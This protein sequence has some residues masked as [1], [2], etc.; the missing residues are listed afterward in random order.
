MNEKLK[1]LFVLTIVLL[2]SGCFQVTEMLLGCDDPPTIT[3][4]V[5]ETLVQTVTV[6]PP[7]ITSWQYYWWHAGYNNLR[8]YPYQRR[9]QLWYNE[10]R[11]CWWKDNVDP[12]FRSM[13]LQRYGIGGPS[14]WAL[15]QYNVTLKSKRRTMI[16]RDTK[17]GVDRYVDHGVPT[18]SFLRAVLSN[19]LFEAVIKADSDNQLALTDICR[20]IHDY[21]PNT[22][23]GSPEAVANWIKFHR[24][25]PVEANCAAGGDRERREHFY[26]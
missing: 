23:H 17:G 25:T 4:V 11:H 18:G 10:G 22:C 6:R 13:Q 14:Y 7:F 8:L 19:N 5:Q 24:A 20:Y 2:T 26:D 1:W 16:P 9:D 12:M 3:P 15:K 21:T